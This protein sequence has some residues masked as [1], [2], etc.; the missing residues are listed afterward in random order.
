[1]TRGDIDQAWRTVG[2]CARMVARLVRDVVERVSGETDV[3]ALNHVLVECSAVV[4]ACDENLDNLG[5]G[6][7]SGT[8]ADSPVPARAGVTMDD[9]KLPCRQCPWLDVCISRWRPRASGRAVGGPA[10]PRCCFHTFARAVRGDSL[11]AVARALGLS[12]DGLVTVAVRFVRASLIKLD[13]LPPSIK[14]A[15]ERR[16][17]RRLP[18]G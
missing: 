15:V 16:L 7:P 14:H 1:M 13:E 12:E 18:P 3:A 6:D 17:R 4:R 9:P 11:A 5:N 10:G 8:A 2:V